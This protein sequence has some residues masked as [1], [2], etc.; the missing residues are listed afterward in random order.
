M[1]ILF[2][3]RI[4]ISLVFGLAGMAKILGLQFEVDA[5]V[6]W[7][8]SIGFMYFVGVLEVAGALAL[9][10]RKLAPFAALCLAALTVGA[11]AT[12][13]VYMEWLPALVTAVVLVLVAHF[14][15]S[16]RRNLFP[17]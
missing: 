12:R 14:T 5:F 16:Q 11:L 8:F 7:G 13:L 4:V 2:L 10:M 15:W 3:E 17:R 6:G 9:W 1:P